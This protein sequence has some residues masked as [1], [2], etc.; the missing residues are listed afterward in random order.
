MN[1]YSLSVAAT[2]LF[3]VVLL[4]C[5]GSNSPIGK[6]CDELEDIREIANDGFSSSSLSAFEKANEK[7]NAKISELPQ[8]IVGMELNTENEEEQYFTIV[9]PFTVTKVTPQYGGMDFSAVIIPVDETV[10]IG[11]FRLVACIDSEPVKLLP[12]NCTP[13]DNDDSVELSFFL[14][15]GNIVEGGGKADEKLRKIN[16]IVIAEDYSELV[17]KVQGNS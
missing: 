3:C 13:N 15:V 16:R 14:N 6:Y 9:K 12:F 8:K 1:K 7:Y 10:K 11:E 2:V 5:G 4:S 17:K